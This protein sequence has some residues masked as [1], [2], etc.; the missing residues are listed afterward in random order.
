MATIDDVA[1]SFASSLA[2]LGDDVVDISKMPGADTR[3]G[4]QAYLLAR[5]LT[6]K[7]FTAPDLQ[8]H[9]KR[10]WVLNAAFKVQERAQK[11]FVI[12]FDLRKD[13]NKVLRG[14]PWYFQRAPVIIHEY[15]GLK[16]PTAI[17][18]NDL[19]FWVKLRNIPPTLEVR[20]TI[21]NTASIAGRFLEWD[22]KLFKATWDIR[23]HVAHHIAK[24]FFLTKTLKLAPG[25]IEEISFFFENL[26]GRCQDCS[27]IF[28]ENGECQYAGKN[29]QPSLDP[30]R[31]ENKVE[32][33]SSFAGFTHCNFSGGAFRFQGI[34]KPIL[35][36]VARSLFSSGSLPNLRKPMV[37]RHANLQTPEEANKQLALVPS[38]EQSPLKRGRPSSP[39]ASP[40]KLKLTLGELT[41]GSNGSPAPTK[42]IKMPAAS[43][44]IS[45]KSLGLVETP[46][47]ML[48]PAEVM[49]PR[50][51]VSL[52]STIKKKRGRPFGS[53][54]KNPPKIKTHVS[55]EDV[56]SYLHSGKPTSLSL[57]GK[58][59]M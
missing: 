28:H 30:K 42:K 7:P 6:P 25:V 21:V 8:R 54:N 34:Q 59:K 9:F 18:M 37:L 38:A 55:A 56:L 39:F 58:E 47:G 45:A 31:V 36:P 46:G 33:P 40:K 2:L 19:F 22:E 16:S 41:V 3:R 11:R 50:G 49:M 15:D 1:A 24:P 48:V 26:L 29:T 27:L 10:I 20:N 12:S 52:D 43:I 4:S 5:P 14:G 35:P 32:W 17:Q 23:V 53:R 44:K 57:K 51:A 13:R